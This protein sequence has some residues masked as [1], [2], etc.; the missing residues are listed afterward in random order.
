MLNVIYDLKSDWEIDYIKELFSQ[1]DLIPLDLSK[2]YELENIVVVFTSNVHS[3]E[4]IKEFVIRVKPICIVHL[5]D[6]WGTKP[7]YQEL[8]K[9]T[10]ILLRQYRHPSYPTYSNI[11][12]IPLGY[13]NKMFNTSS[14]SLDLKPCSERS[15]PWS[16]IGNM[17]SDR[18][19]LV[20]KFSGWKT[21]IV[22]NNVKPLEM[23]SIY[24]DTCFVPC[25][26]G[27]VTLDCFRLYEAAICGAIPVVVGSDKEIDETFGGDRPPW[28][29]AT[30]WKDAVQKCEKM[31][32]EGINERQ[33][34]V[35][36]WWRDK[37]SEIKNLIKTD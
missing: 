30:S 35:I 6:E 36:N 5:S 16:F 18:Y 8:C 17:K 13:M 32:N 4:K 25:G 28:I 33:K 2:E 9:Y 31:Y 19:N 3:Y 20:I 12:S 23:A 1:K 27:N 24:M 21:G 14:T 15:I 22:R 7:E 29:F 26:R 10:K 37:V 34:L 11:Y